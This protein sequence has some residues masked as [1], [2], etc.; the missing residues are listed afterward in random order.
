MNPP[1]INIE[2]TQADID[3]G[4]RRS[5]CKCPVALAIKRAVTPGL[6]VYVGQGAITLRNDGG[7]WFDTQSISVQD[8]VV[9]FDFGRQ[10]KPFS[11]PLTM[12]CK[13]RYCDLNP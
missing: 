4:E 3:K 12:N 9:D 6:E 5:F 8:F 2:V 11:F 10:V 7:L 13:P 1:R